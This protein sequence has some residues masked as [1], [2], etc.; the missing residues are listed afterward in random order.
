MAITP[1]PPPLPRPQ[2]G[3]APGR[4][5]G[6]Q[7]RVPTPGRRG[8][9]AGPAGA[10]SRPLRSPVAPFPVRVAQPPLEQLAAGVAGQLVDEVDASWATSSGPAGRPARRGSP[11][12]ARRPARRPSAGCDDGLDLLAPVL[13][14]DAEHRD[15][16]D[17][18]V[19]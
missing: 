19:A 17:L 15:V 13:V 3:C 12:R 4:S 10:R 1:G 16:G 5:Q 6:R 11:R 2:P 7:A 18:R 14:R 9:S 8:Q